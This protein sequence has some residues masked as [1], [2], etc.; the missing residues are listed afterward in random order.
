[1]IR[2]PLFDF[3]IFFNDHSEYVTEGSIAVDTDGTLIFITTQFTPLAASQLQTIT[4]VRVEGFTEPQVGQTV[5]DNLSALNTSTPQFTVQYFWIKNY[6]TQMKSTETFEEGVTY[7]LYIYAIP[8]D[9]Y[10][11][12]PD[13]LP[14][15]YVNGSTSYVDPNFIR[16]NGT[17]DLNVFSVD[18]NPVAPQIVTEINVTGFSVPQVGETFW[19]NLAK[20]SVSDDAPYTISS[21]AWFCIKNG[22]ESV[23][24][25][26]DTFEEGATYYLSVYVLLKDGY[27]FDSVPT[28]YFNGSENYV[29]T[30]YTRLSGEGLV[31][32][33][34]IDLQASS[35]V[36]YGD[37]NGDGKIDGKDLI[38]L[39]KHLVGSE[40]EIGA[41]ADVNGDGTVNGKDL[42]RLRKYL[43]TEDPS[44]LGNP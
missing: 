1:M 27:Y 26:D 37:V 2:S 30:H 29:D 4:E 33:F 7:F 20:L 21:V 40:V 42:I 11:F 34:S 28:A 31:Q 6:S 43:L 24:S 15:V 12:D 39:R 32:F 9:N 16:V 19:K 10:G 23:M 44:L 14:S 17:G 36:N 25:G 22:E 5:A 18:F 8:K 3:Y 35:G 38:R 13:N 41:G